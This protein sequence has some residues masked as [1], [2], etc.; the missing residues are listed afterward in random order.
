MTC[1]I[2]YAPSTVMLMAISVMLT[3]GCHWGIAT[4]QF[5]SFNAHK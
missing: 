2:C 5:R 1:Y 3:C 4:L